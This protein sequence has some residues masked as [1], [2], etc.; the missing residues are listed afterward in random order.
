[1]YEMILQSQFIARKCEPVYR[2]S[3]KLK[4]FSEYKY[5]VVQPVH[6]VEETI[7]KRIIVRRS[8]FDRYAK[9]RIKQLE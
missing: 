2:L 3:S 7:R 9:K 4:T 5:F 1:M 8:R 6:E